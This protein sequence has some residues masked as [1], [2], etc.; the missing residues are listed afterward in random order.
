MDMATA[1]HE[2]A[3]WPIDD[4]LQLV[5][6]VWDHIADSGWQPTLSQSQKDEFDRR[7]AALESRPEEVVTWDE[8]ESH[9]RR[10]R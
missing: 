6:E 9:G 4:R 7:L 3:V 2:I 5:Q 1:L 10:K 8:I